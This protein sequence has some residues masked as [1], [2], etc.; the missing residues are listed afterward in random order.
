MTITNKMAENV[1]RTNFDKI[2]KAV[3]LASSA[4]SL[5]LAN[6]FFAAKMISDL[7]LNE[8]SNDKGF[9]RANDLITAVYTHV[10]V[11]K[12]AEK[13][14]RFKKALKIMDVIPLKGIV[15]EMRNGESI[16]VLISLTTCIVYNRM[17]AGS[18]YTRL[19]SS[20]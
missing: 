3:A 2:T 20:R 16:Y 18:T 9:G 11:E 1:F 17:P 10:N 13:E 12:E 7:R 5:S 6:A 15:E 14:E 4:D 19:Y 8:C